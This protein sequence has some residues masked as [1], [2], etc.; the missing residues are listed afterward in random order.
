MSTRGWTAYKPEGD[1]YIP[2]GRWGKDHWST[3]AYLETVT[4]DKQGIVD[5]R[6]MRTH[7]RIHRELVGITFGHIQD[8]SSYPTMLKDGTS[9]ERH[10]DWSCLEDMVAAGFIQAEFHTRRH[11]ELFGRDEARVRLTDL[12]RAMAALLREHKADGGSF[13]SFNPTGVLP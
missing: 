8:G 13:N 2:V 7:P 5:N 6:R 12:G 3:F 11:G 9:Q 1:D 10:D 4:V